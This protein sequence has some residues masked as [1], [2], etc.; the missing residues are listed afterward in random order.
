MVHAN[1]RVGKKLL[2]YL[3]DA[4][5]GSG[6]GAV[7][8]LRRRCGARPEFAGRRGHGEAFVV[9][10]SEASERQPAGWPV[11]SLTKLH[12]SSL[13][14]LAPT[15]YPVFPARKHQRFKAIAAHFRFTPAAIWHAERHAAYAQLG[16]GPATVGVAGQPAHLEGSRADH[17]STT[18]IQ[19]RGKISSSGFFAVTG[20]LLTSSRHNVLRRIRRQ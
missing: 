19:Y 7:R 11:A 12:H 18:T 10:L 6:R 8:P 2:I 20:S 3:V 5:R 15:V 13:P 14:L 9:W 16:D 17:A 4:A 1:Q